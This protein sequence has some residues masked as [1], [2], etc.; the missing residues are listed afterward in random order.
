MIF[1]LFFY[2]TSVASSHQLL[3]NHHQ[4]IEILNILNQI[5]SKCPNITKLYDLKYKSVNGF[6]LRVIVLSDLPNEHEPGE[7][8]FKYIANMHGNEV[9]GRELLLQLAMDLCNQYLNNNTEIVRLI[10]TTRIHLLITMNPDGWQRAVSNAWKTYG[11]FYFRRLEDMLLVSGVKDY[12][13]GRTNAN[14]ID[15]NRNFPDLVKYKFYYENI[16]LTNKTNLFFNETIKELIEVKSDCYN[17]PF[18]YET[19]AIIDWINSIPFVLSANLHDGSMVANYPY[20]NSYNDQ[21][22]Y[23]STPDDLLFRHLAKIYSKNHNTMGHLNRSS[24]D[25]DQFFDGITNGANWY[26]VCGGK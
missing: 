19:F 14:N 11:Q 12:L 13:V 10:E 23:S 9:V 5:N 8:E 26:P 15:L 2:L 3:S 4:N 1:P 22:M 20:D 25:F 18:Q 6:P 17:K 16:G 21:Q 7:P 24:C